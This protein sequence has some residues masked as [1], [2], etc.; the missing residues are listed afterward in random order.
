MGSMCVSSCSL[1]MF[2][3]DAIGTRVWDLL[4]LCMLRGSFR[5]V[6]PMFLM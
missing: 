4:W 5:F 1:L 2:V 3:A 6:F